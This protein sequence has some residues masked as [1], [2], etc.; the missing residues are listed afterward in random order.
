[1]TYGVA[2]ELVRILK[3]LT[4]NTIHHVNNSKEF[5]DDIKKTRLEEGEC[6]TSYDVSSLL[7]TIPVTSAIEIIRNKLQ[8]NTELPKRTTMSA[9]NILELLE[10]CLCNTYFL[11][12]GQF[13]EHTKGAAMG[14]PMNPIVAN[15]YMESFEDRSI[16]SVNPP[17]LWKWYVDDTFVILQQ[18]LDPSI[19]FTTEETR[20][21]GTMPFL[22]TLITPQKGGT[23]T[24][25]M[26]GKP[27]HTDLYLQWD[28]HH[29]WLG[30]TV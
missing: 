5:A 23:L 1:M 10:F 24:T 30:T 22:D 3:P 26:H 29:I 18:S 7:T 15:L 13:Y 4:G 25:S 9:I 2:K 27:T 8:Q 12:Q 17:R 14:S 16:A 19:I 21:D 11:F 6:V 28:S 20:H